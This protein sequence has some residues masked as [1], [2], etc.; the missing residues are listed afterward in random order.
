MRNHRL[1]F[2]ALILVGCT[3]PPITVFVDLDRVTLDSAL[4]KADKPWKPEQSNQLAPATKVIPGEPAKDI[5]NLKSDQKLAIRKEVDK[6]VSEAVAT[7]SLRLQDYYS[8]EIDDF[9]KT[10]F[11]KLVPIKQ[12]L[13]ESFLKEIRFIFEAS[14]QKRGPVLTR[15][16]FLTKFPPP[17]NLIPI[18]GENLKPVEVKRRTEIRNL[19]TTLVTID[20]DYEVD[21]RRIESQNAN[22]LESE[23]EKV[24]ELL[25][26]RQKEI[27]L[28]AA[29]EAAKLVHQFSTGL[30]QRIFSRYTF[31]LSEIPTKTVNFPKMAPPGEVPRVTFDRNQLNRNEKAEMTKEL[32][33]FLSLNH[34]QRAASADR[35][36]DVTKEFIE[37]RMNLKSGHW[38]NWQKPSAQK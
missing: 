25:K 17:E 11:A 4:A 2:L 1:V 10:E 19:Q 36:K 35:A 21:V 3:R 22:V 23:T 37:W 24:L 30:S 29:D 26:Q 32:D 16:S 20:H 6:Q 14:A 12:G 34:Y 9:Y 18:E 7:I 5:E 31:H 13:N 8:R 28:R 15:L 38:E 27:D 33:S